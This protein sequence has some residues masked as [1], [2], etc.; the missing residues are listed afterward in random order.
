M[1]AKLKGILDST[2]DGFLILD[3][4]GVGYRVFCSNKTLAKMPPAGQAAALLIETQV[5]EDHIHLFGFADAV[6]KGWFSLLTTVQGVGAKV[7]LAILS[8]LN[9]E[10]LSMAVMSGDSKSVTR[11]NG[12][13]PKLAVRIVTELKGK[14]GNF[15]TAG[16]SGIV[17]DVSTDSEQGS[18]VG[19]AV[20]ALVN[21][22]YAR[23]DAAMAVNKA[24]KNRGAQASV[25]DLIRDAL[26]E[27]A[28]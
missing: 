11:A 13:G 20:S 2:G 15:D 19:D 9:A 4:N 26:K 1:I 21:L 23:M 12:V 16:A 18:A 7:A 10:E 25:S 17:G 24:L 22:G 5:R 6:E 14:T 27:F 28:P 8:V 3:V